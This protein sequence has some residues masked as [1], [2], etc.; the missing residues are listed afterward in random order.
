MGAEAVG[1]T[2][3]AK[4]LAPT[5]H[6]TAGRRA[7]YRDR[8]LTWPWNVRESRFQLGSDTFALGTTAHLHDPFQR[9]FLRLTSGSQF[10]SREL[11]EVPI[12]DI[13]RGTVYRDEQS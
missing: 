8:S 11:D 4:R 3:E 12:M 9:F 13:V 1:P 7:A 2:M 10:R 5:P 6:A